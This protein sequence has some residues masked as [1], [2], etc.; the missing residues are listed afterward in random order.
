VSV[1]TSTTNAQVKDLVR[2]RSRRHRD[3]EGRFLIEGRREIALAMR[4]G[5]EIRRLVICPDLGGEAIAGP[6]LVEMTEAPFRKLSVRQNPDG[7]L[8]VADH[9][10]VRLDRLHLPEGALV[11]WVES[12]EK[13]GNLGA[14]LRTAAA[15]GV[16][17]VI[18][19]DPTT[20][21][22]NPNVVRASQGALF[23]VAV[24]VASVA[25]A[26]ERLAREDIR[27]VALTPA[28]STSLWDT[29]LGGPVA[30]A[31]GAE[32]TGLSP[33]VLKAADTEVVIPMSG[34][35]D[36]LNASVAAAVVLYEAARQ[37]LQS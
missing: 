23:T 5:V 15:V 29:D 12:I 14:M 33:E 18:V 24:A 3:R 13:P 17:G 9:L 6:P 19:T 26:L 36:S 27:L 28:A 32:A 35:V 34:Q 22:H 10:D 37:R 11:L 2:L 21:I 16:D 7:F 20:D 31:I 30:V 25:E 1:I 4:G 8:A